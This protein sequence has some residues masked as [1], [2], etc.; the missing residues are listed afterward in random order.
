[1]CNHQVPPPNGWQSYTP[2]SP[3]PRTG[4]VRH[5]FVDLMGPK[6]WYWVAKVDRAV[7]WHPLKDNE[8]SLVPKH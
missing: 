3:D 1:M 2:L 4:L 8:V 7:G 5:D 6:G